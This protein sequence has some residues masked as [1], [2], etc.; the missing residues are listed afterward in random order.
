M[1]AFIR[2]EAKHQTVRPADV[3]IPEISD[4]EV[5]IEVKAFGVHARPRARS[6]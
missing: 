3:P 2:V 6:R 4:D 5:L 1:N